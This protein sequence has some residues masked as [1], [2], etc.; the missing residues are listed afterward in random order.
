MQTSLS[1]KFL[2]ERYAASRTTRP[3]LGRA[4][5]FCMRARWQGELHRHWFTLIDR[6][7]LKVARDGSADL[8]ARLQHPYVTASLSPVQRFNLLRKH[9][10]LVCRFPKSVRDAIYT[11]GGWVLATFEE[12]GIE[13]SVKLVHQPGTECEGD[14][15]LV[16]DC[17]SGRVAMATFA[18]T[19]SRRGY[20]VLVI[21]GVQGSN[22]DD[23][24][25][26]Y[27][28]LTRT[29]HGLRPISAL[30]HF[31]QL[32]ATRLG[33]EVLLGVEDS[34]HAVYR[35]GRGC[36]DKKTLSYDAIWSEHD[37]DRFGFGLYRLPVR[38][39]PRDL[40]EIAS[41]KRSMYRKRYAMLERV[42]AL[43]AESLE[44]VGVLPQPRLEDAWA[45]V[46]KRWH[47]NPD[48]IESADAFA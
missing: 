15:S 35:P 21:G 23:A 22:A 28:V 11:P 12:G 6:P 24:H 33:V 17:S 9:F 4:V 34:A 43:M 2:M 32:A 39:E 18:L 29:M 25:A 41:K 1:T 16:W 48:N 46:P 3:A 27:Q 13:H 45:P 44:W 42:D 36:S 38:S 19:N 8:C 37:G 10:E 26:M 30:V 14:L 40:A 7:E 20:R 47:F 31:L 5:R